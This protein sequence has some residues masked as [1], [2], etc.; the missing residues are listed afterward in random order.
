MSHPPPDT[1]PRDGAN[2]ADIDGDVEKLRAS[3]TQ[4]YRTTASPTLREQI[5]A[6]AAQERLESLHR[7]PEETTHMRLHAS[8]APVDISWAPPSPVR[9][10]HSDRSSGNRVAA[11]NSA[12]RSRTAPPASPWLRHPRRPSVVVASVL[13]FLLL[14]SSV[15]GI[16]LVAPPAG[17]RPTQLPAAFGATPSVSTPIA[18]P[19]Q[20][21]FSRV[22]DV[23][24]TVTPATYDT[25]MTTLSAA[26]AGEPFDPDDLVSYNLT[27]IDDPATQGP[28]VLPDGSPA[29]PELR[30]ELTRRYGEFRGCYRPLQQATF[31]TEGGLLRF[32]R[33]QPSQAYTAQL[34]EQLWLDGQGVIGPYVEPWDLDLGRAGRHYLFDFRVI[35]SEHVV[36]SVTVNQ[37]L[38]PDE[39]PVP[40]GYGFVVFAFDGTAWQIDEYRRPGMG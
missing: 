11:P 4:H 33:N 35:D 8:P 12:A 24:C 18:N 25:V 28:A 1:P 7:S 34:Y 5:R 17:D 2:P 40:D 15:A 37:A 3:L 13:L 9:H 38:D 10:P 20:D 29:P 30:D 19:Q 22:T 23:E 6:L 27:A 21:E 39:L 31:F 36:A 16:Y 14:A 32:Y 26:A